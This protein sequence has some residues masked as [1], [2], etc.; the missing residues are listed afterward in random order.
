MR[1][2]LL[3]A[4]ILCAAVCPAEAQERPCLEGY[5][6]D[7]DSVIEAQVTLRFKEQPFQDDLFLIGLEPRLVVPEANGGRDYE[8]DLADYVIRQGSL[9]MTFCVELEPKPGQPFQLRFGKRS[10]SIALRPVA[11]VSISE[12]ELRKQPNVFLA[13]DT[14]QIRYGRMPGIQVLEQPDPDWLVLNNAVGRVDTSG[15]PVFYLELYNPFAQGHPSINVALWF[16]GPSTVSCISPGVYAPA[17][18]VQ[19]TVGLDKQSATIATTDPRFDGPPIKRRA[20]LVREVCG[21][22]PYFFAE[23]GE[24]GPL[25]PGFITVRYV[26]DKGSLV[27]PAERVFLSNGADEIPRYRNVLDWVSR[28]WF[29]ADVFP[30]DS[31]ILN[32]N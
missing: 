2:L 9:V 24:T 30:K 16:E 25:P 22:P 21:K 19:V 17:L 3:T 14:K 1:T 10:L 12:T 23:L 13:S 20:G 4:S 15:R 18:E 11:W 31:R 6:F 7:N 5:F 8:A 29:D 32:L 26:F 28:F 27:L